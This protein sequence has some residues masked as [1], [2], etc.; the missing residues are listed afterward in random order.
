MA[1]MATEPVQDSISKVNDE[2]AVGSDLEFQRKW[3]RFEKIVWSIFS[4]IVVLT[5]AGAF[6]KGPLA[7]AQKQTQDGSVTTKYERVERY[8]APSILTVQFQPVAIKNGQVQL[9]VGSELVKALGNQRVIPQPEKSVLDHG[10]ILY[11]FPSAAVPEGVEF[12]LQPKSVGRT[13][14]Q[15]GVPGFERLTL[16]I[17]TMP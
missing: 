2:V 12:E 13:E 10:G 8:G 11:T 1:K 6:G 17:F 5:L 16:G 4:L 3:W 9:W 14:L 7:N 15:L